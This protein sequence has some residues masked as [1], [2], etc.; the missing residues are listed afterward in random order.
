MGQHCEVLIG[1]L[2]KP[3]QPGVVRRLSA[4]LLRSWETLRAKPDL[5]VLYRSQGMWSFVSPLQ[6]SWGLRTEG[7]IPGSTCSM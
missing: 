4:G 2:E 1:A 5:G 7:T 6:D 3:Q